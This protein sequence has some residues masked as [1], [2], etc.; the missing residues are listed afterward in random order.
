M[1]LTETRRPDDAAGTAE[2]VGFLA[3]QADAYERLIF[4]TDTH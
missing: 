2:A 4:G 1:V 3:R